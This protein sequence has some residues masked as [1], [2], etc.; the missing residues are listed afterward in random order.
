MGNIQEKVN[1]AANSLTNNSNVNKQQPSK[2]VYPT[3]SDEVLLNPPKLPFTADSLGTIVNPSN[4][5]EILL[6]GSNGNGEC[7]IYNIISSTFTKLSNM[8]KD[9]Y[10]NIGE[11]NFPTEHLLINGILPNTILSLGGIER[12]MSIEYISSHISQFNTINKNWNY[13]TSKLYKNTNYNKI[14]LGS[15][16]NLTHCR[17]S[18]AFIYDNT[19]YSEKNSKIKSNP[20]QNGTDGTVWWEHINNLNSKFLIFSGGKRADSY[21]TLFEIMQVSDKF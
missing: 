1:N 3:A 17:G 21:V 9:D 10:L 14:L 20:K 5:N 13:I 19:N 8:K 12:D 2:K 11:K 7:Y 4:P 6:L 18:R 16:D 15:K